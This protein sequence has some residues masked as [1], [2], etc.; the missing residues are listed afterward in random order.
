MFGVLSPQ[1]THNDCPALLEPL[2]DS[3]TCADRRRLLRAGHEQEEVV[4]AERGKVRPHR[5]GIRTAL[6]KAGA[7]QLSSF[8]KHPFHKY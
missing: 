7:R 4:L 3:L 8:K 6:R 2:H 1:H 5:C